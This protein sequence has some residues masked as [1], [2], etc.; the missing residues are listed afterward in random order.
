[1]LTP[2]IALQINNFVAQKPR[3]IQD[4][5]QLI[6]KNW[7]TA[8]SYV[9][10]IA[11]EQGTIATTTFRAGTKGGLKIVY[12]NLISKNQSTFQEVLF[13]RIIHARHKKDFSPFDIYQYVEDTQKQ[14]F[15]EKQEHNLNV[16]QDLISTVASAQEQVLIFSGDVSWAQA[17]QQEKPLLEAFKILCQKGIPIKI[18]ANV[19]LNAQANVTRVLELNQKFGK[20]LIEIRHHQ[21]PLRAF[22]VD[23]LLA[24]CK[25]KYF[26]KTALEEQFLFYSITDK[27]WINWLKK[28][29]WH[30]FSTS[31]SAE[32]RLKDLETI[33][34]M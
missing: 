18:I 6:S 28:V 33:K 26:L 32:K 14:C 4:I 30:F 2:N 3:T 16:K 5:A 15:L 29:F 27:D 10:Q 19:D 25:E 9:N 31:V 21:Q 8:E 22:I 12:W 24:R 20:E 7:R 23:T 11:Q 34:A 17:R 13:Q 1:M